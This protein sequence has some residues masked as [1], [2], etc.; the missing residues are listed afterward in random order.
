M[1]NKLIIKIA[2]NAATGAPINKVK[3]ADYKRRVY[4]IQETSLSTVRIFLNG[5]EYKYHNHMLNLD[6]EDSR[7]D[8]DCK[9]GD[10]ND[11]AMHTFVQE[12]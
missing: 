12:N 11:I 4:Q 6:A 1:I 5:T 7:C 10:L 2:L 9:N 3:L 8:N